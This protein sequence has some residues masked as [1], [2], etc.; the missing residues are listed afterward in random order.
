MI[1][2][3]AWAEGGA[4]E[5]ARGVHRL[6]LPMPGDALKAVNVYA[7]E[8]GGGVAL[9]DTGWDLDV[10]R[11]ALEHGLAG[12]GF[13][14]ADVTT[15]L[16]T[17]VH[18][19]HYGQA[20]AIRRASGSEVVLGVREEP[21]I[22]AASEPIELR[23]SHAFHRDL[24]TRHGAADEF[25]AMEREMKSWELDALENP[26]RWEQ[27]DRYVTNGDRVDLAE[28]SLLVLETPGHTRGHVVFLDED[29]KLLFAGD[30]V[31]PHITPS[32]GLEP[33]PDGSA[34]G[35]FLVSLASVRE[36]PAN[37]VLPGHGPQFDSLADRVD[38]LLHHHDM[39]LEACLELVDAAGSTT[40]LG[41]ARDLTWT[42]HERLFGELDGLNRMLAVTETVA[43]LEHLADTG[44]LGRSEGPHVVFT[45]AR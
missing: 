13:S 45:I 36:L 3:V 43:H 34:L 33:F 39:R 1:D 18:Q 32:L 24:L 41:V 28:R 7:I 27:P 23:E 9:V 42:R 2:R 44:R 40:A 6:P 20:A 16:A 21:T 12:L 8:D 29:A 5:V 4:V 35:K 14:S 37:R 31:L 10:A 38:E 17:H 26:S 15:V 25:V 19:D 11:E 30:H 22:R